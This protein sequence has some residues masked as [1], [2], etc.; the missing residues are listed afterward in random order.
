MD[1]AH[2]TVQPP[3]CPQCGSE[4]VV[5]I[6]YGLVIPNAAWGAMRAER[7]LGGCMI[8]EDSPKW[9][10]LACKHQFGS[11]LARRLDD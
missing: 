10:C 3:A 6:L 1:D 9:A 7:V 5:D 11:L 8:G 4:S 2:K